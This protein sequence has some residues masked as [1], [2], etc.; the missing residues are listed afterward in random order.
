MVSPVTT[1]LGQK[2]RQ[3]GACNPIRNG[4]SSN[5][6][7]SFG[8]FWGPSHQA[9]GARDICFARAGLP[10]LVVDQVEKVYAGGRGGVVAARGVSF[11]VEAGAFIALMG[12]SG[13]GQA[14]ARRVVCGMARA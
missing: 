4:S 7:W 5:R 14:S 10:V 1:W 11:P 6:F 13:C 8:S 2:R 3:P 12:P 9:T